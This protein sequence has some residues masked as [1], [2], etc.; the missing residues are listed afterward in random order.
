MKHNEKKNSEPF[1]KA[2]MSL[3]EI[4]D[5]PTEFY[6]CMILLMPVFQS[7]FIPLCLLC[8]RPCSASEH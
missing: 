2:Q 6:L 1:W 8:L 7:N 4:A 5:F 3:V